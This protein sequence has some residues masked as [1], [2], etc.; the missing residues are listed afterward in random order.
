MPVSADSILEYSVVYTE[1]SLNHMSKDFQQVMRELSCCFREVYHADSLAIV[2]GGGTFGM[3]AIARQFATQKKC[4]VIRNGWF[5]YR[6]TQIFEA[7]SL[8]S[9]E[10]VLKARPVNNTT[11]SPFVPPP[12]EEVLQVIRQEKPDVVFAAHVETSAGLLLPDSYIQ[13]ITE[14]VHSYGG[15]FVLD[16]IASGALW[17]NM[18]EL[19][20][21]VLLTAPQKGWSSTPCAAIVLMRKH[22][23]ERL[24]HT[25]SSSFACDLRRWRDIMRIYEEGGHAYHATMPTDGLRQLRDAIVEAKAFGWEQLKQAQ[26][27][28]GDGIRDILVAHGYTSVADSSYAS[29]SVV[30]CYTTNPQMHNGQAFLAQGMQIAAGVPLACDEKQPF[31][32]F[33]IGLFGFD[34]LYH[35]EETVQNFEKVLQILSKQ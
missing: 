18:E 9:Q 11:Q 24:L 14:A 34:K 27:K 31:S 35:R 30:V 22:A 28:L 6:W 15:M 26:K 29:P 17:V 10:I 5:S 12:I 16:C 3:E 33:R 8:P 13:Q 2:P 23:E 4:V 21:D 19:A 1:R 20:V 32:T 25:Q 7:C